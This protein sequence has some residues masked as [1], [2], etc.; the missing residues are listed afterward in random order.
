MTLA[1]A[2][3]YDNLSKPPL[4]GSGQPEIDNHVCPPLAVALVILPPPV[5]GERAFRYHQSFRDWQNPVDRNGARAT[6]LPMLTPKQ[7]M[8]FIRLRE[9]HAISRFVPA[10][11]VI[12]PRQRYKTNWNYDKGRSRDEPAFHNVGLH[13]RHTSAVPVV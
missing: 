11:S 10:S 12:P 9:E 6:A 3:L 4:A 8:N 7:L 13:R 5:C 2:Q 1:S